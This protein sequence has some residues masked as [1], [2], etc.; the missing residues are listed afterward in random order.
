MAA[1]IQTSLTTPTSLTH[2][3]PSSPLPGLSGSLSQS[4]SLTVS[5]PALSPVCC[6]VTC[7]ALRDLHGIH[8]SWAVRIEGS[9]ARCAGSSGLRQRWPGCGRESS[10]PARENAH[11]CAGADAASADAVWERGRT[12]SG[13]IFGVVERVL[14]GEWADCFRLDQG[15][16]AAGALLCGKEIVG[17]RSALPAGPVGYWCGC[18]CHDGYRHQEVM[19]D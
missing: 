4:R 3:H 15:W 5:D 1:T 12:R 19:R 18:I 8:M 2:P 9:N 14:S 17:R 16:D 7:G 11:V 10:A 13:A 6:V